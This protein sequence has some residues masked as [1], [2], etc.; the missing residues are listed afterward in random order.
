VAERDH[1]LSLVTDKLSRNI[2]LLSESR[3][4]RNFFFVPDKRTQFWRM[5]SVKVAVGRR[6]SSRAAEALMYVDDIA[7]SIFL[8]F[9][10]EAVM[11]FCRDEFGGQATS[12]LR[13]LTQCNP[14]LPQTNLSLPP[15]RPPNTD[16]VC[17]PTCGRT[18]DAADF[19]T[20]LVGCMKRHSKEPLPHVL[21]YFTNSAAR[22][23]ALRRD[24]NGE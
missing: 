12:P 3:P 21:A 17:C 16:H 19:T 5:L 4:N 13:E 1:S 14:I 6:K 10:F 23:E 9:I 15:L 24:G 11:D 22:S 2:G 8:D 7:G 18:L 20:H